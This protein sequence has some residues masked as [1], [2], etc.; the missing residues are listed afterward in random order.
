M[1]IF[2]K[3]RLFALATLIGSLIVRKLGAKKGTAALHHNSSNYIEDSVITARI[4]AAFFYE[5]TLSAAEIEVTTNNGITELSGTV[6]SAQDKET[7]FSIAKAVNGVIS[8]RNA[9]HPRHL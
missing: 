1:G 5:P 3:V 2:R 6:N 9:I 7:A 8:V 4:K